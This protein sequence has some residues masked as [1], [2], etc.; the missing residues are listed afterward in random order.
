VLGVGVK[1]SSQKHGRA[2]GS[3]QRGKR[4]DSLRNNQVSGFNWRPYVKGTNQGSKNG[5]KLNGTGWKK[6]GN[7]VM[8]KLKINAAGSAATQ[9]KGSFEKQEGGERR[10]RGDGDKD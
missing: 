6:A 3:L 9:L 2:R 1:G 8:E 10:N 7:S 5:T 4:A